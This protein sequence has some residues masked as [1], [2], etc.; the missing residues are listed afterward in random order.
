[1]CH[2]G[3]AALMHKQTITKPYGWVF[4]YQTRKWLE[5]G[6]FRHAMVGNAPII[7]D[8]IDGNVLVTGTALPVDDY[9]AKYEAAIPP[10]RLRMTPQYPP[11]ST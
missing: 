7:V 4:F 2:E 11:D 9:L 8:R 10:A 6:D 5:T 3:H 1:V